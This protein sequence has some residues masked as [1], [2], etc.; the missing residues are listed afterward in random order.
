[1]DAAKLGNYANISDSIL[2]RKVVIESTDES[3]TSIE[4]SSV[5]GNAVR[6]REGCRLINTKVNPGL[7]IP[8]GM[9]YDG[10]FLQNYEDVVKLAS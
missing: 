9:V 5:I 7:T 10:K 4:S 3:V 1:M 8:P 2:G 6:I